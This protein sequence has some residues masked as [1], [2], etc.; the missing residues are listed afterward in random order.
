[1]KSRDDGL[2]G[3]EP[4]PPMSPLQLLVWA[5]AGAKARFGA[6]LSTLIVVWFCEISIPL[7]LG[8][9]VDAAV[10][11]KDG[12]LL[13]RYGIYM[14]AVVALLYG[15]HVVYLRLEATSVAEATLRLRR[16]IY[17]RVV[18]QPIEFFSRQKGGEIGHRI[19]NDS[20]VLERHGIL[21]L[22]DVPF[23]VLTVTGAIVIML[24]ANV[25]LALVVICLLGGAAMLAQFVARPLAEIEKSANGMIA[26]LGG[27]LQEVIGGIR[28]VKTFGREKYEVARLDADARELVKIEVK[29]GAVSARLEPLI[30]LIDQFG[31]VIVVWYGAYLVYSGELTPG[32]LVAFIAYM[33]LIS[34]P[35]QRA[36]RYYRQYQQAR[37]TLGRI[38]DFLASMQPVS[39]IDAA[40]I[41]IIAHVELTDVSFSYAG[42]ARSAL[43][44][45]SL[46]AQAGEVVAVV[47]PNGA[48]KST[49]MDLLI[50]LI[51]PQSGSVMVD[52]VPL[53][54]NL[55][56]SLR[57]QSAVLSQAVFLFHDTLLA[58]IRYGRLEATDAEIATAAEN[59]G[60]KPLLDR[61]PDGLATT[62]GDRGAKLSGGERQ[63]VA[64]ARML[65]RNP[66]LI[67]LDEPTSALD[68]A[69]LAD[70]NRVIRSM[71]SGRITFV[72]AHRRE[73]VAVADRVI[74][75]DKGRIVDQGTLAEVEA[76][77]AVFRKLFGK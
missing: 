74:V 43:D 14:L 47:G 30:N 5:F 12:D 33:E 2:R 15:A 40:P 71:A 7:L 37:G 53:D 18:T 10:G 17:T 1:M 38:S 49:L 39:R 48:G 29:A 54:P 77:S 65:V 31:L 36:G 69:A 51:E 9:T 42:T 24:W 23:A 63:R 44:H 20:E 76:K 72:I 3:A 67:I 28:T 25:S 19:M 13:F 62:I 73:T 58:N 66:S 75:L 52:G 60:L 26:K 45:V 6:L 8:E 35:V 32:R 68:G 27:R 61:L 41:R 55:A 22:A 16:E 4:Q 50:G 11:S 57:A 64:L 56:A 59:A 70:T 46:S 34:E 21:L